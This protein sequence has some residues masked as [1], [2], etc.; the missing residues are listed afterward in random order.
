MTFA[1]GRVK[2]HQ[3]NQFN[4]TYGIMRRFPTKIVIVSNRR[5]SLEGSTA[6]IISNIAIALGYI[7]LFVWPFDM[8]FW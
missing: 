2:Y 7:A 8:L 4:Q 1:I 6:K 3:F 5:L